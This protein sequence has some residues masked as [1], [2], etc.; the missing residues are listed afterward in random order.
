MRPTVTTVGGNDALGAGG[1]PDSTLQSGA[2]EVSAVVVDE[3]ARDLIVYSSHRTGTHNIFVTNANGVD[4]RRQL[5]F[6][7]DLDQLKTVP[8][9]A[10]EAIWTGDPITP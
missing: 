7:E 1:T 5:T 10:F 9:D 6:D 8:G 4:D 2:T 3:N